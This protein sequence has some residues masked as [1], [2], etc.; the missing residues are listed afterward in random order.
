LD[1]GFWANGL[2]MGVCFLVNYMTSS[3]DPRANIVARSIFGFQAKI[4]V[5]RALDQVSS[6]SGWKVMPKIFQIC[7]E[8]PRAFRGFSIL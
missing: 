8:L 2:M 1:G 3:F 4:R 7:Q 5:F 6:V